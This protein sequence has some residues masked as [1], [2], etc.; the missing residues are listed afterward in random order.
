MVMKIPAT[1]WVKISASP[2]RYQ[3]FHLS[4]V[5]G[6]TVRKGHRI[7]TSASGESKAA[8]PATAPQDENVHG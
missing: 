3:C 1:E 6:R 2:P 8:R 7:V 5:T 4:S